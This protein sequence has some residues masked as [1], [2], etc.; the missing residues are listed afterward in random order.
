MCFSVKNI[1]YAKETAPFIFI[2]VLDIFETLHLIAMQPN[3][4][5]SI[6]SFLYV[7]LEVIPNFPPT[8]NILIHRGTSPIFNKGP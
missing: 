1:F 2:A 6:R 4:N 7:V 8:Q 3:L 5:Q